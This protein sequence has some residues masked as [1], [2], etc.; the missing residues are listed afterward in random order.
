MGGVDAR[1]VLEDVAEFS[2]VVWPG[3]RLREY[4]ARVAREIAA[5]IAE[6]QGR[7]F[8]VVFARQSGKDEM[9][10][11]LEAYLMCRYRLRGGSLI[12]VNPTLQPQGMIS[13]RRLMQRLRS[14]VIG[15]VSSDGNTVGVGRAS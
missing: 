11:Q 6:G 15:A 9:L 2:R 10:A 1:H 12:V 7:Q 8:A 5:S 14:P 4:Q 13:K 3:H